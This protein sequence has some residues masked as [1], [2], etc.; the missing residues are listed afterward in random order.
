MP[1]LLSSLSVGDKVRYGRYQVESEAKED[2]IW[3]IAAQ[4][5]AGYPSGATTLVT[6]RII[7]LRGFD[8]KEPNNAD[9]N[10]KSSGNNRYRDSNIRQWLNK[11]GNPWFVATH[12]ADEPPT[13]SGMNQP[14]GYDG[15]DGFMSFFSDIELMGLEETTLTV[16][17]NTVTDGGGQ[18][19][20]KDKFFLASNT[21]VGLANEPGGASGVKLDI[22]TNDTSR[23]CYATQQA[24]SNTKSGSKPSNTSS[25]W[26][27]WLRD[28]NSSSSSLARSVYTGGTLNYDAAFH[29]S[30]GVRPL[31]NLKSGI[32]VSD[33]PDGNG[34]YDIIWT[35]VVS[36]DLTKVSNTQ[37]TWTVDTVGDNTGVKSQLHIFDSGDNLVTQGSVKDGIGTKSDNIPVTTTGNFKARVKLW[38]NEVAENWSNEISY[39]ITVIPYKITLDEAIDISKND[40]LTKLKFTPKIND[41]EMELVSV[42]ADKIVFAIEGVEGGKINL[43][44]EGKDGEIDNV[45]YVVS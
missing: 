13:D 42:E 3:Q 45:A 18:E 36:D 8:A 9:S 39:E 4:G 34:I 33:T 25:G 10:R 26:Y 43:V 30:S 7:D 20:V 27:W 1:K 21:E 37:F 29:G 44:I 17:L 2:I 23:I 41:V 12:G 16:A 28:P 15:K 31:C 14:T 35:N 5:H 6:E 32:L 19:T 40:T 38:S 11:K 22:F 24:I